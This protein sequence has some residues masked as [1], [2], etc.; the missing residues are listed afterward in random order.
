MQSERRYSGGNEF[1]SGLER[2][3]SI[4]TMGG[5][6]GSTPERLLSFEFVFATRKE[7]PPAI[8]WSG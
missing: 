6:T 3:D 5:G 2:G 4:A 7:N 1:P 8:S